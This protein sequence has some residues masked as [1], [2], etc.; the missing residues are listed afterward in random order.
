[1][2]KIAK[3]IVCLLTVITSGV[4]YAADSG[5]ETDY[6]TTNGI[7][8]HYAHKGN[9]DL[10]LFLHGFPAFWYMWKDQLEDIGA[11]HRAVAPD[12]R[13]YN[14]STIPPA[15]EQYKVK[16]LIEDVRKF[17]N[18]SSVSRAGNLF[19]SATIGAG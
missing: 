12:M 17:A 14:L 6:L 1:M 7:K 8:F 16:Y 13:G 9:G 3:A 4:G 11:D 10:V 18:Q 5:I 15:L 19:W 2:R